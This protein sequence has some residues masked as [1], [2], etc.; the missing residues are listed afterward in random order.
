M[1]LRHLMGS[2]AA[3]A[4]CGV[5]AGC[6]GQPPTPVATGGE[7]SASAGPSRPPAASASTAPSPTT[8]PPSAG[9]PT[10]SRLA[11]IRLPHEGVTDSSDEMGDWTRFQWR[12]TP[13]GHAAHPINLAGALEQARSVIGIER[14]A[15]VGAA[16]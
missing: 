8:A 1:R 3:M 5:L 13:C 16:P 11:G 9:T 2:S 10:L 7:E 4:L 6:T 15:V 12:Y 14:S